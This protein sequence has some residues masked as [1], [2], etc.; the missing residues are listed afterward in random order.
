MKNALLV[1]DIPETRIWLGQ[2][3]RDAFAQID[4]V[5]AASITVGMHACAAGNFD[6]AIVD[7]ELP[8]GS[9]VA[10]IDALARRHKDICIIVATIYDDDAHIFP[11]LQAG[12]QGYLLKDQPAAVLTRQLQGILDGSPP[13]SPAIARRLL[14]HF[15]MTGSETTETME[16]ELTTRE[17]EVLKLIGQGR[18]TIDIAGVLGISHHTVSDHV[19]NIYRKLN[20]SSRA[21]AATAASRLGLLR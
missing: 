10:V 4:I 15:R 11:A 12:A 21:Q 5:E 16:T 20:I 9:G 13:L 19:K 2:L 17:R 8:D 3:L 6:L 7:L 14:G 18:K 1:E